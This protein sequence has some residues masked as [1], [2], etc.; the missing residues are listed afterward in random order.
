MKCKD[1][2]YMVE[3]RQGNNVNT[4]NTCHAMPPTVQAVPVQTLQ[5]P[6]LQF[7][8]VWPVV[9]ADTDFCGLHARINLFQD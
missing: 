6:S 1:C 8:S 4:H 9:N 5:G 2:Q 3:T 7:M